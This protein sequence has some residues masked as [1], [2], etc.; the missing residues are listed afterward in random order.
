QAV[1]DELAPTV[2]QHRGKSDGFDYSILLPH[3]GFSYQEIG[4]HDKAIGAFEDARRLSPKDPAV[5]GYLIDANIAAKK[6]AAAIDVANAALAD[7]PDDL[8]LKRLLA[9]ALR[10][11]GKPEQGIALL[12]EALK[13]QDDDPTAYIALAQVYADA[14]RGAQAIKV[15]QDA[16]AKFPDDDTVAFELG[17]AY[18]RQKRYADAEGAFQ[19]LLQRDPDNAAALNYL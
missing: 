17:A 5:A 3:L 8:R 13:K 1:I 19:R 16:A 15:M 12:E 11:S 10:H 9:Q 14:D 18:D 6:Y 7:N 4:Q 2:A